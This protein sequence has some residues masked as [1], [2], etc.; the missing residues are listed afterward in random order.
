MSRYALSMADEL[1]Q[2][3]PFEIDPER[4]EL[5]RSG[6]VLRL[7]RQPFRILLLLV[8]RAGEVVSREEIQTAIW[9]N[10]T[11]VDSSTGSTPQSARSASSSAITPERR[12]MSGPFRV[13]A[14]HSSHP[15]SA[16]GVLARA[17][18]SRR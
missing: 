15:W 6:L 18:P 3:G 5:R 11:Y 8:R 17:H 4:E 14:I 13:A 16:L 9:G 7:P 1:L 12:V 10:E 2:F